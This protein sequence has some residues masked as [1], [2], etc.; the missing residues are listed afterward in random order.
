MAKTNIV[1][2][3]LQQKPS[4][5]AVAQ[6]RLAKILFMFTWPALWFMLLAYIIG[7]LFVPP[8]Q[9][10]PTPIFLGVGIL[11]NGAELIVALILLRREGYKLSISA[12]R[13]RVRLHWPKGWKKWGLALAV[14]VIAY[15]LSMLAHPLC[16]SLASVPGFIP[17]TF[18]PPASDPR[19]EITSAAD[20]F[21][22]INLS[23]NY[24]FFVFFLVY[25]FIF[26]IVGEELY[27]RGLLLPK[28]RGVFGKWDWV[29]NGILFTLKHVYQR[30]LFPGLLAGSLGLAFFAGPLGSLPLAMLF[31]WFANYFFALLSM[32]PAVFGVG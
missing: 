26:N 24:L 29:A 15:A 3:N 10:A 21:P 6:Y 13:E 1:T 20:A 27:Y 16:K 23:G 32:I 25:G 31:H 2:G 28:M 18:W 11:G 8:G 14:F 22:D 17:P 9:R 12:L 19:V 30:W 7:P 5:S 4:D